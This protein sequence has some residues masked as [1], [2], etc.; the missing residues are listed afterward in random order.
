MAPCCRICYG[1]EGELVSVCKCSGSMKYVHAECMEKWM[2]LSRS[3]T[4]NICN[5]HIV[6]HKHYDQMWMKYADTTWFDHILSFLLVALLG[7]AFRW[8]VEPYDYISAQLKW[9]YCLEIMSVVLIVGFLIIHHIKN[10]LP[11]LEEMF[12]MFALPDLTHSTSSVFLVYYYFC[13][14]VGHHKL[15]Y[16]STRMVFG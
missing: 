16:I 4:C 2:R 9:Y 1:E 14:W 7:C 15:K 3:N 12:P 13:N 8:A 11:E 10:K 6:K 5:T